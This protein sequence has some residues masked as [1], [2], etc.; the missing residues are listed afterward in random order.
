MGSLTVAPL[1]EPHVL[2][3]LTVSEDV[4]S[5]SDLPEDILSHIVS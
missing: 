4:A 1:D 3:Q 2:D 5:M